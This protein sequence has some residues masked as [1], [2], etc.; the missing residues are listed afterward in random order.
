MDVGT[1][2]GNDYT[3]NDA[4]R[5]ER[6]PLTVRN[7]LQFSLNIPSVKALQVND[8]AT[9]FERAQEFGL[10]FRGDSSNAGLSLALGTQETPPV[11]S[12]P[13]RN[14]RQ[15]RSIHREHDDPHGRGP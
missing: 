14:D 12:S 5:L 3:P 1:D 7:A 13:V 2:F 15:W 8:P 6:G 9:V 4:D 11:D 10:R